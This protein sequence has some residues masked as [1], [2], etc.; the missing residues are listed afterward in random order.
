LLADLRQTRKRAA[1][2]ALCSQC[3]YVLKAG[4]AQADEVPAE[5]GVL[6]AHAHGLEVA[7]AAPKRAMTLAFGT[8]M[9]LAR[10][11]ADQPLDGEDQGLL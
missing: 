2:L 3:W 4:I 6:V 10:A 8:W 9:A 11:V 1:Y 7:R 5:C